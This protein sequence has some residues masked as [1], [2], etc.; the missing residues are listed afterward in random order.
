MRDKILI[1]AIR[2]MILDE[3][4]EVLLAKKLGFE[5]GEGFHRGAKKAFELVLERLEAD[6]T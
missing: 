5:Y 4:I 3:A 6:D 2:N 1:A